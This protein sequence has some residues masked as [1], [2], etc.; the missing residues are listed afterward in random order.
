M[1]QESSVDRKVAIAMKAALVSIFKLDV[2]DGGEGSSGSFLGG[3][4]ADHHHEGA[5]AFY[6]TE[7]HPAS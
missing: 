2:V 4:S 3:A 6:G 7:Y 5:S 1:C